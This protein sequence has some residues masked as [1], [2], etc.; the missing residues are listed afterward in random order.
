MRV[1]LVRHLDSGLFLD[2]RALRPAHPAGNRGKC[3]LNLFCYTGSA[4]CIGRWRRRADAVIDM[5]N[6]MLDGD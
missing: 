3:F 4:S 2:H 1:N 5:S 6:T